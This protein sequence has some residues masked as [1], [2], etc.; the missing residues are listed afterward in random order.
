MLPRTI[1][2]AC[3][4]AL[5]LSLSAQEQLGIRLSNYGGINSTLL[6]PAYHTST[7]FSWDVN[8]VEGASHA[9]N[10]YTY[11]RDASLLS[12]LRDIDNLEVEFGPDLVEGAQP[13]PGSVVIDFSTNSLARGAYV[14]S[15]VLGPSFYVQLGGQHR[16]GLVSRAR[17]LASGRN[18]DTNY[19][20]YDYDQRA[21]FDDFAV[22][23][24]RTAIGGWSEV[25]LNYAFTTE[26]AT[27]TFSA[28][29][30]LKALQAY[31][32]VYFT[33]RELFRYQK[34]PN[35]SIGSTTPANFIFGLTNNN[36]N[37]QDYK[38]ERNGGGFAADL[39]LVFTIDGY[40]DDPYLWKFGF[41]L[42]DLGK[43]NYQRN[44]EAHTVQIESPVSIATDVYRSFSKLEDGQDYLRFFSSQVLGDSS[45]SKSGTSFGL[46]L[47]S[48]ISFQADRA[49]GGPFFL[50]ATY[51]QGFPLGEAALQR[52][53][54]LAISPR[55]ETRWLEAAL[56]VSVYDWQQ[57]RVGLA[58]RLAFLTIGTEQL[59]SIFQKREFR[60]YDLY[61]ALKVNPFQLGG[62]D[63]GW[64]G[65]PS[66]PGGVKKGRIR[67]Y[68]F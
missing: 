17:L 22:E 18:I 12:L 66:R 44:A 3:F 10:N 65:R 15:S 43:L 62:K 61:F 4:L 68:E 35:D 58:V 25:G 37:G 60:G 11:F 16:L 52:G 32:G 23:P 5:F 2:L 19:S 47:P 33:N 51:T 26:T 55:L 63:D 56:P 41:S 20:Y 27:G 42:L 21:Y 8:L 49:L 7:P 14:M 59:G 39:G 50:G 57:V 54:L 31:E 36:L 48:A 9:W 29:I 53:S 46:W 40:D 28:G 30:T 38:A 1:A 45:A 67:C 34:L 24:F 6:N 13:K 64:G